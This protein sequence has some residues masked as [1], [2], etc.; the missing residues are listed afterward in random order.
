M[1]VRMFISS[2]SFYQMHTLSQID[3][4]L[5]DAKKNYNIIVT[6]DSIHQKIYSCAKMI[7]R[8]WE[9]VR[10]FKNLVTF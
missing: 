1:V 8:P 5:I 10:T 3:P 9:R 4:I 7:Y 2:A 6:D